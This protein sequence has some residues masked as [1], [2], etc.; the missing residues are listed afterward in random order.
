MVTSLE[1]WLADFTVTPDDLDRLTTLL[2]ER[3][4]PMSTRTLAQALVEEQIRQ[5][6]ERLQE[7][8]VGAVPYDPANTYELG[9]QVVFPAF[10]YAIGEVQ[11]TREGDNPEYGAFGVMTVV[12]DDSSLNTGSEPRAFAMG[13]EPDHKLNSAGENGDG[14]PAAETVSAEQVLQSDVFDVVVERV[15]EALAENETLLNVAG[16]WFPEDLMVETNDGHM[17]LAEAVL[18]MFEGGPLTT[19]QVLE[20]IGGLGG[21]PQELQVFSMN[22]GMNLDDRFDEVGPAGEVLWFLRRM[23][24]EQVQETPVMLR[25]MPIPYDRDALSPQALQLEIELADEHSELPPASA[26]VQEARVVII[27][28]HRRAGTLPLNQQAA[29]IF[30]T[31]R[32]T[33]RVAVTLIDA[34]DDEQFPAWVVRKDRY[35]HGLDPLYTKHALP[36]GS[37]VRLRR[38]EHPGEIIV[39]FDAHR[40]RT[41]YVTIVTAN[42]G[43][44]GFEPSKRAIGAGYD[45]LL[46]LGVDDLEGVDSLFQSKV[47][48]QQPLATILRT[49][50]PMLGNINAQGH[51]HAKTLYSALNVMRRCPP[52]PILATL[53]NNPDFDNVGEHY[54][55]LSPRD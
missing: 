12:F 43:Q 29:R 21:A 33:E 16:M 8:F 25:Y 26:N 3:E 15:G 9:Q 14:L 19:A 28:P 54:W 42:S 30:P 46:L 40:P 2:L 50:I 7:R 53:A 45:D 38:G 37:T 17:H 34:Q 27:Y 55:R 11:D 41:E 32:K 6:V 13:Y 36:I 20:N 18:D 52:G 5:E 39:D 31:A 4:T 44:V 24:P 48:K 1:S 23:E 49:I 47:S 10:D 35:V 22:F 51:V